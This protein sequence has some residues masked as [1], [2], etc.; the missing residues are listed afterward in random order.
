MPEAFLEELDV[1]QCTALLLAESVGRIALVDDGRPIVLPINYRPVV[2][3]EHLLIALRTR[4]EGTIDHDGAAV[5]FEIDGI[6]H[7]H[8]RGWSVLV[9][10]TLHRLLAL[11]PA[12]LAHFDSA[13]WIGEGRDAWLVIEIDELTG[14]TLHAAD[15]EWAFHKSAYL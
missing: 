15:L 5:A 13:P 12:V 14:R 9:R 11:D 1:A 8:R 6:D 7:A 2:V 10:G 4:P 3:D